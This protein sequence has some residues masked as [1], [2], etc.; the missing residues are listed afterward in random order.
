MKKLTRNTLLSGLALTASLL[1]ATANA[2]EYSITI[3]NLTRG[4][5][6]TPLL[7]TAHDPAASLFETG[8][9][10]SANLQAMAEGGDISGLVSDLQGL[11]ATIVENPAAG[12]L[13]PGAMTETTL[14]TG[15]NTQNTV[16][17]IVAMMLP[18]NDGFVGLNTAALPTEVGQAMT[19][20]LSAYDA[21][22]EANDEIRGG[23]APGASGFPA[24]GPVDTASGMN[25]TGVAADIE[26]FIHIHR[27]VLGDTSA[28]DGVSDI[29]ATVHR[30]LNPVASVR[31]ELISQ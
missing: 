21:G 22:T 31:I 5:Y 11:S 6:F 23:G 3:K 19:I 9:A 1:S 14:D 2:A 20:N 30:W 13:A 28:V 24:P 17:S 26:G 29:D 16:L 27:N 10:A 7:V 25:G 18:T 4:M 8:Q 15:S 12:L